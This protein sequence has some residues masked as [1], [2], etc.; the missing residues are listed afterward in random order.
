MSK[1]GEFGSQYDLIVDNNQISLVKNITT[2]TSFEV[3]LDQ[4][5]V[6]AESPDTR[7]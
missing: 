6:V 3:V 2:A 5:P 4:I 7:Q 1:T